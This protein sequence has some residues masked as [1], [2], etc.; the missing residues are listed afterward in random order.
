MNSIRFGRV[1]KGHSR[2]QYYG[3]ERETVV[4]EEHFDV[5][6]GASRRRATRLE[7]L[8]LRTLPFGVGT[9]YAAQRPLRRGNEIWPMYYRELVLSSLFH[10]LTLDKYSSL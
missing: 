3:F 6:G 4:R 7:T 8:T 1:R 5:V 10:P 2:A 9:R